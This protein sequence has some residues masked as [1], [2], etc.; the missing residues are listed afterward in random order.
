MAGPSYKAQRIARTEGRRVAEQGGMEAYQGMGDMLEGMQIL[1]VMDQATRPE[2]AARNG[3]I[4]RP[5]PDGRP[6]EFYDEHGIPLPELPDAPNCRCTSIPVL[7]PPK[8]FD[9]DPR[10]KAQFMD[11]QRQNIPDPAAYTEWWAGTEEKNRREAV[12]TRRYQIVDDRLPVGQRPEWVDFIDENGRLLGIKELKAEKAADREDRQALVRMV[13]AEREQLYREVAGKGFLTPETANQPPLF[14][15]PMLPKPAAQ[16]RRRQQRI[17]GQ[18]DS[19]GGI[20]R[21]TTEP[22]R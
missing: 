19:G 1:A 7:K 8:E 14:R 20:H 18:D 9:E 16:S 11:A 3:K 15:P 21:A 4:Y 2:H 17:P 22:C 5:L 6:G 10:V 12:G 13:L